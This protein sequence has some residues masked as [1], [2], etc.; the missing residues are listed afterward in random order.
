MAD[1]KKLDRWA[2]QLLDT[3]KRNNL[4][5]Y[6]NTK[7][8]SAEIVSPDCKTVFSKCSVGHVFDI[9]DP[10]ITETDL[11]VEGI[12]DRILNS[13]N[14]V[15]TLRRTEEKAVYSLDDIQTNDPR[16]LELKSKIRKYA[17]SDLPV[18]IYGETG[19]GKE[20]TAHSL[21]N[22]SGRADKPFVVQNCSSIPGNLIESILFGTSKGAFTGAI[23]NTGLLEIADGGTIFLDEINSMP[24]DLQ[25]KILRV[26]Q[27]GTFRRVGGKDVRHVDVRIISSTN[28]PL[29]QAI[30]RNEFRKDLYYRLSVLTVEIP[31]LRERKG[32]IPLLVDYFVRKY[33]SE[34]KKNVHRVSSK[35]YEALSHYNMPGNVR[36]LENIIASA[37]VTI[38]DDKEVL[39]LSDVEDRLNPAGLFGS[40]IA[41]MSENES[42]DMIV[43]MSSVD[44]NYD[45]GEGTLKECVAEFEKK[46]IK[47]ALIRENGNVS[48]AAQQLGVPRQTLARKVKDYG[49]LQMP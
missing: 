23:E 11:D 24:M 14:N 17:K 40:D 12:T 47:N 41:S 1:Q 4:I 49:L 13:N 42:D 44:D 36:E 21:H 16:M 2:E 29:A 35:V 37:L 48:K 5:N 27:D 46:L 32:D 18:L 3:G 38:D 33:D 15:D 20:L 30:Q 6:R 19:T 9:F 31:P 43:E 45:I 28:E 8:S 22:L 34:F 25:P 7:A 10:K 39:R 26:I